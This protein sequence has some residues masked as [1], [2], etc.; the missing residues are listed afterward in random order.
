M[1]MDHLGDDEPQE[2]LGERRVEARLLGE[3]PEPLDLD[4]FTFGVG[5]GQ[6][7]GRL[8]ATDRLGDLE[9]LGEQVDERRI[10]VVDRGA[11][12]RQLC[13]DWASTSLMPRR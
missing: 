12:V 3:S 13:I 2:L 10:D 7:D 6:I 9:P 11:I 5:G 8:V 1:V 4:A